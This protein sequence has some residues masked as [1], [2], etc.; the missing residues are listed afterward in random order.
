MTHQIRPDALGAFLAAPARPVGTLSY[1]E[2]QG[3]FFALASAPELVPPSEWMPMV[4]DEQEAGY[5]TLEEAQTV[6]GE[7]MT[8]YNAVNAAVAEGPVALPLDCVFRDDIL[9]NLDD[10]APDCSVVPRLST[11]PSAAGG[12]LECLRAKGPR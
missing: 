1:H 8:L 4:F 9:A 10:A 11:R 7:L 2:V 6:I 5:A 12:P 3:F